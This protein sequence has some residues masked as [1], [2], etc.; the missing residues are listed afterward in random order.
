MATIQETIKKGI[1]TTQDNDILTTTNENIN[2]MKKE[3][4]K[5]LIQDEQLLNIMIEEQNQ[6][7]IKHRYEHRLTY[8]DANNNTLATTNTFNITI[9]EIQKELQTHAN[10][11]QI[12]T[13][14]Y[15]SVL[16]Q[17]QK[18]GHTNINKIEQGNIN[19]IQITT[20]LRK[21]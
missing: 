10:K 9:N 21:A 13:K 6:Q 14:N 18:L 19:T 20:I 12:I 2:K 1:T 16:E 7:K 8:K 5:P 4:L 11:G 3:L 17:L 15:E